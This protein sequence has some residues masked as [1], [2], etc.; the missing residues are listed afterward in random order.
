MAETL[1]IAQ[2]IPPKLQALYAD[3]AF[4]RLK[5]TA[6]DEAAQV[7]QHVKAGTR[8]STAPATA[9]F[10]RPDMPEI[11]RQAKLRD[12]AQE[13]LRLTKDMRS[14]YDKKLKPKFES[15]QL[16]NFGQGA[17][18]VY[19]GYFGEK[20][21]PDVEAWMIKS[22]QLSTLVNSYY[23]QS[24]GGRAGVTAY[25]TITQP[26]IPTPPASFFDL[27]GTP[28]RRQWN[29]EEQA[30]WLPEIEHNIQLQQG[31]GPIDTYGD[32]SA[33]P[34]EDPVA[35]AMRKHGVGGAP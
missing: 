15:G 19:P 1:E 32:T 7:E 12:Q 25:Q 16:S 20:V 34:T 22:G 5:A 17:R 8:P 3:P 33:A 6:P 18:Y 2:Q 13:I 10:N 29:L 35:A 24:G 21:D 4:R 30:G 9:T 28:E 26:H 27:T 31:Q 23:A 14:L 11:T